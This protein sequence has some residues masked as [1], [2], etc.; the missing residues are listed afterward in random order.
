V[1]GDDQRCRELKRR[2]FESALVVTLS[3]DP[4]DGS[5]R[6]GRFGFD[7][8]IVSTASVE[9]TARVCHTIRLLDTVPV[10]V[11]LEEASETAVFSSLSAGADDWLA[12][13]FTTGELLARIRTVVRGVW[14]ARND[15]QADFLLF[16]GWSLD[17][18][19]RQVRNPGGEKVIL[20]TS[21]YD[22]LLA[23]CRNAGQVLTRAQ[24]LD[25]S[26]LHRSNPSDKSIDVHIHNLRLKVESN[27][28]QPAFIQTIRSVGYVFTASVRGRWRR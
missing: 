6:P 26:H 3:T 28:R 15:C 20:T 16:E 17:H 27:P 9:E 23:L 18:V 2:L 12:Y 10:L 22:I 7:L 25:L 13:P 8:V 1:T 24:L 4:Q 19:H 5:E 11:V 21:E 14:K